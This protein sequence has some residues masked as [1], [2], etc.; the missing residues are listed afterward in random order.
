MRPPESAARPSNTRLKWL[1]FGILVAALPLAFFGAVLPVNEYKAQGID[2]V[3]CDGSLQVLLFAAPALL[4]YALGAFLN[5]RY[6]RKPLNLG[7][8]VICALLIIAVGRNVIASIEE[9]RLNT[10]TETCGSGL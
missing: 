10:A 4:I 2:A 7:V 5:A 6:P 9:Q 1:G 8:A 3:D